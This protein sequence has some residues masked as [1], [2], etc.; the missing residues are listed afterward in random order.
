MINPVFHRT[1]NYNF[2][3]AVS[4]RT[5]KKYTSLCIPKRH[6][7]AAPY[8]PQVITPTIV[9]DADNV[10]IEKEIYE[11]YKHDLLDAK[12]LIIIGHM[13]VS[14]STKHLR[15]DAERRDLSVIKET[16]DNIIAD[17]KRE[18]TERS[19]ATVLR[20]INDKEK[21]IS[22]C[23]ERL[24]AEKEHEISLYRG[25]LQHT[26]Q[27]AELTM[28]RVI[29]DKDREVACLREELHTTR[30]LATA[31]SAQSLAEKERELACVREELQMS[32]MS[33]KADMAHELA[34]KDRELTILREQLASHT[35]ATELQ[36]TRA[37]CDKDRELAS[38]RERAEVLQASLQDAKEASK[39]STFDLVR[40]LRNDEV[41]QLQAQ[42]A[43]LKGSNFSKGVVGEASVKQ[44]LASTFTECE[45]VDKS[46]CAAE[47]DLHVVR[48]NGEFIAVECKNK[49]SITVQ[50]VDKSVRDVEF[51]HQKYGSKFVGYIFV[52]LRSLNIPRKGMGALEFHTES[53]IPVYWYAQSS[54][55]DDDTS[56]VDFC[57]ALWTISYAVRNLR[58]KLD[59]ED[60]SIDYYEKQLSQFITLS[61]STMERLLQNQ[62]A[63][64]SIQAAAKAIHDTN[65]GAIQAI[66]EYFTTHNI[67]LDASKLSPITPQHTHVCQGCKKQFMRKTDLTKHAAK[68]E[69]RQMASSE[70]RV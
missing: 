58:T 27:T 68:C 41:V 21:D 6:L 13:A 45:I 12:N 8:M 17:L 33:F 49:A 23:K 64:A 59:Q 1:R 42:I 61:R 46:G 62:K 48:P 67:S 2:V 65:S 14:S 7:P 56:V 51:L 70:I 29:S 5:I 36:V 16:Y 53:T 20:I 19:E 34:E 22:I 39:Q 60:N 63:I 15:L 40:S 9:L 11:A 26:Q 43:S 55:T 32:R 30:L 50:D 24:I 47:S 28:A 3:T 54:F 57:R 66:S 10:P 31:N 4:S 18:Y 69:L 38:L 25:Q 44:W 35:Q 37:V 52:S